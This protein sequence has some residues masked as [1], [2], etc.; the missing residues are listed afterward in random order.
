MSP[1]LQGS[2]TLLKLWKELRLELSHDKD[3]YQHLQLVTNFWRHA[4][5]S[6]R[7]LDWDNCSSWPDPW[8]LIHQNEFDDSAV[9]LGM[10]YT[11]ILST[12]ERWTIDRCQLQ[13]IKDD[14]HSRQKIILQIDN[15]WLMN[16]EYNKI[17]AVN[18]SADSFFVQ[19]RYEFNGKNHLIKN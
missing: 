19:Q 4:P 7:I 11:L 2:K 15:K 14:L 12:D 3:D 16:F 5:V 18:D 10:F 9:S 6:L 1:F 17:V 8:L 13:L